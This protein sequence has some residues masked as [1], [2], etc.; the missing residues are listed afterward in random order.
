MATKQVTLEFG[1]RNIALAVP[2][3]AD[4]LSLPREP[5]LADPRLAILDSLRNPIGAPSLA[6]LIERKGGGT[7]VIV[8]SDNTRPVPYKGPQGILEPLVDILREKGV[9]EITLLVATGTH[10]V[11]A[12][13]ELRRLLP[14]SV[15]AAGISVVCHDCLDGDRLRPVGTTPR[16]TKA[17]LN[18]H[19]LDANI[20]IL[21][22]LVE[23]HF[24]AGFSGGRK[25]ICPGI[26]GQE[27][28][29]VFHGPELMGHALSDSFVL[30]G[31]P[32]HEESLA[33]ARLAPP[34]F[35]VNVT[36]NEDRDI[37]GVFAGDMELAH[38]QAAARSR[39]GNSIPIAA[40]YDLVVTHAGF[41]GIN[42]YQAAKAACE[43]VKAVRPGG[44][45]LLLANH[46]DIDP[47]GGPN[48]RRVLPL[49]KELGPEALTRRLR[50]PAWTFVPE[51]WEV[52]MWGRALTKLGSPANLLY[53]SPQLTGL[54]FQ[55]RGLPGTDGGE[56][57][58]A[59]D[60]YLASHPRATVAVLKDGPYGVPE[61][62]RTI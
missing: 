16:G 24:M 11:L 27:T 13:H 55:E 52:Q 26:V 5:A 41:V 35:I 47:V 38:E 44:T 34:D 58:H 50:S 19:Y 32:C 48:Y 53:C 4:V 42:H 23:P 33:I 9:G 3:A 36:L 30:A 62:R 43:G 15:F 61:L 39:R 56:P 49:L 60:A 59:L 45:L 14:D 12:E 6:D 10:R 7:A 21:T 17:Q 31:N 51:Q 22:G 46:T 28:T 8:V 57:Q 40:E 18:T 54:A 2:L 37:T 25:S 1:E 29:Y 20:R